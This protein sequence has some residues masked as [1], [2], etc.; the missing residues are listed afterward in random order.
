MIQL[1]LAQVNMVY[2]NDIIKIDI[3][4]TVGSNLPLSTMPNQPKATMSKKY[5]NSE[6]IIRI[7]IYYNY[8]IK[9]KQENQMN[10]HLTHIFKNQ[11]CLVWEHK[12]YKL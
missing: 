2:N 11:I 12:Y 8:L 9:I 7:S 5:P 1:L 4:T 3:P 10:H 6:E